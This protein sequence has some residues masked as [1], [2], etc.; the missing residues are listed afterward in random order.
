MYSMPRPFSQTTL[1]LKIMSNDMI[2]DIINDLNSQNKNA[3]MSLAKSLKSEVSEGN[4]L[5]SVRFKAKRHWRFVDEGR[6]PGKFVP[7]APLQRWARV[8]L[9]LDDEEATK[10]AFAI[11]KSI[12]KKGIKPTNIFKNNITKFK[13]KVSKL[14][15]EQGKRDVTEE[16]RKILNRK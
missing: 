2:D 4:T 16:I 9:G 6:K 11:S 5:V 7:I 14:I 3:S 1:R 10:A 8:K 13:N 15:L 12:Q